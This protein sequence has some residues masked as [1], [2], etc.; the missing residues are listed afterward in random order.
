[1]SASKRL[2]LPQGILALDGSSRHIPTFDD[3]HTSPRQTTPTKSHSVSRPNYSS[4]LSLSDVETEVKRFKETHQLQIRRFSPVVHEILSTEVYD[5]DSG[6]FNKGG[7][8]DTKTF[9]INSPARVV[10][11]SPSSRREGS[12]PR[13]ERLKKSNK[14]EHRDSLKQYKTPKSLSFEQEPVTLREKKLERSGSGRKE[15]K[16][17]SV[18][19][20]T[21]KEQPGSGTKKKKKKYIVVESRFKQQASSKK[22]ETIK[23]K[24]LELSAITPHPGIH[25]TK[26]N[27]QKK[28][29]VTSTPF[30]MTSTYEGQAGGSGSIDGSILDQTR[31][32]I[33]QPVSSDPPIKQPLMKKTS[34]L[35]KDKTSASNLK[36]GLNKPRDASKE[37]KDIKGSPES[38]QLMVDLYH[39]RRLQQV[40]LNMKARQ[41]F[42]KQEEKAKNQLY[43]VWALNRKLEKEIE[44]MTLALKT[45]K[46][47]MAIDQLLNIQIEGIKPLSGQLSKLMIKSSRLSQALSNTTHYLNLKNVTIENEDVLLKALDDSKRLIAEITALTRRQQPE[48]EE[49]STCSE[50]LMKTT[51]NE[52]RQQAQCYELLGACSTLMNQELSLQ[53]QLLQRRTLSMSS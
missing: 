26:H 4:E 30:L 23:S 38:E 14:V 8:V 19:L 43:V 15:A 45:G 47:E 34:K 18:D 31:F 52:L 6:S 9:K 5:D 32:Q 24:S 40:Y 27:S 17:K 36:G 16:N 42:E 7:E 44:S 35:K 1:M 10:C 33:G 29:R 20:S 11:H 48:I 25:Q 21:S 50:V 12:V 49:L 53:A 41:T 3:R 37:S 46:M 22:D 51:K 2:P 39:A 28:A 13:Q